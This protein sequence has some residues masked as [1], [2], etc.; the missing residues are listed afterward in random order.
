MRILDK[1]ATLPGKVAPIPPRKF[2]LRGRDAQ[3]VAS[4]LF[5]EFPG[6]NGETIEVEVSE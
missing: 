4:A 3:T 5:R 6:N 1:T 2:T